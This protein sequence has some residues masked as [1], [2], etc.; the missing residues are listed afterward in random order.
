[1]T[2]QYGGGQKRRSRVDATSETWYNWDTGWTVVS[3]ENDADGS[4]GSLQR[5]YVG[6]NDAHVDGASP[7]TG[8]WK[9]YTH[10]H[11]NSSRGIWNQDKSAYA[12]IEHTPYGE[13][14]T[15][16]GDASEITRRYTGHDWDE[17]SEMYFALFRYY[18]PGMGRWVSR[19]PLGMV[20][21]PNVYAYVRGQT[22]VRID[23]LGRWS[24]LSCLCSAACGLETL[25]AQGCCAA[26]GMGPLGVLGVGVL[27]VL[28]C[29]TL[30]AVEVDDVPGYVW[31]PPFPLYF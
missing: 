27:G 13:I 31:D 6:R 16:T 4:S 17:S 30:C 7:S 28:F 8:A 26:G 21:G 25:G 5:T 19:D 2:Y 11:L 29:S 24:Q 14:L 23:E 12:T 15:A 20:D 9:Y 1:M 18:A 22:L 3:E 10:D